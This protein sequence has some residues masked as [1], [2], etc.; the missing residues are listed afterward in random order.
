MERN[1]AEWLAPD[2]LR[3][4]RLQLAA[5]TGTESHLTPNEVAI[6]PRIRLHLPR[7]SLNMKSLVS[8]H[9]V[10]PSTLDHVRRI[11]AVFKKYKVD[12]VALLVVPGLAW[13]TSDLSQLH[14]WQDEGFQ[15]AGHGWVHQCDS[16][17]GLYHRCHSTVLSRNVAEHLSLTPAG[18]VDLIRRCHAWFERQNLT[19]PTL[20]VP[21]AWALGRLPRGC[22]G[23]LP[24]RYCE[25]LGG[26]WD[27]SN[28][29]YQPMPVVGFEA[30]TW[31]RK[32]SLRLLNFTNRCS[33]RLLNRPLRISIHP[34]DLDLLLSQDIEPLLE[35]VESHPYPV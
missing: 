3:T 25:T 12:H 14:R 23:D 18:R 26:L 15:L 13:E 34:Y 33:S 8:I 30:D 5:S 11:L 10:M 2:S 28:T 27:W 29:R 17:R 9:D 4:G 35:R 24:F 1:H 22:Q 16:I 31:F 6:S 21:P 20:Y 32:A 19:P 7:L